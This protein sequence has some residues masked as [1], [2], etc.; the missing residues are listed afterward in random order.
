M[1]AR[2]DPAV[3][4]EI[5]DALPLSEII[6]Q[7]VAL[8]RQGREHFGLCP[9][10]NERSPS[11]TV[12]DGKG[13]YHCFGCGASGDLFRWLTDHDGLSFP[14]AVA[15]AA[16]LAGISVD[17]RDSRSIDH[18]AIEQRRAEAAARAEARRKEQEADELRR[19]AI[20][21]RIWREALPITGT[22]AERYLRGRGI[23]VELPPTLRYHGATL[24]RGTGLRLPA[25]VGGIA[26]YPSREVI[27][28]HRTFLVERGDGTVTK[29][30]VS[31][32]KS[33]LGNAWGGACR[34]APAAESMAIAGGLETAL[35]VMQEF[36]LPTWAALSD[37]GMERVFLPQ[38][39]LAGEITI[40]A[41]LDPNGQGEAAADRA[42]DRHAEDGRRV[43]IACPP[44]PVGV[45]KLDWN[46]VAQQ[47]RRKAA[48]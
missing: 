26:V 16:Q 35:S 39:P 9:F 15:Y 28:V 24:H 13:F 8:K 43:R 7:R 36:G 20:A 1:S 2:I 10:H 32:P 14:Q 37:G 33:M 41:D 48:A 17:I 46:D 3:L 40:G 19:R 42:F 27:A 38:L 29:A 45:T 4:Q 34:L 18:A 30:P 47:R 5:R 21:A 31:K 6:G 25:L 44:A 12:T 11:F 22:P 23:E